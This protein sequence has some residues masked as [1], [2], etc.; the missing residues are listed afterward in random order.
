MISQLGGKSN[1][2]SVMACATNRLRFTLEQDEELDVQALTKLPCVN[3]V[4]QPQTKVVH[5]LLNEDASPWA[6]KLIA[7]LDN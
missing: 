3:A 1:I 7:Q 6:A 2:N 4:M 5:L